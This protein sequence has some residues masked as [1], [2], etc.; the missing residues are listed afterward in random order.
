MY[1]LGL[2]YYILDTSTW[3]SPS[4]SL[5]GFC[6]ANTAVRT[7]NKNKGVNKYMFSVSS[8]RLLTL[9]LT[10]SLTHILSVLRAHLSRP[11]PTFKRR[12]LPRPEEWSS[13]PRRAEA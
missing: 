2:G 1:A 8:I 10:L 4:H 6:E 13:P 5:P 3:L 9:W 12:R 7:G 11:G